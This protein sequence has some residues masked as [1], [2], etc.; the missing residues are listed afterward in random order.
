MRIKHLALAFCVLSLA[1]LCTCKKTSTTDNT[2]TS[3]PSNDVKGIIYTTVNGKTWNGD[4]PAKKYT[5]KYQDS[6]VSFGQDIYGIEGIIFG[7]TLTINTAR[8][9]GKDSSQIML[10]IVLK[11]SPTGNYT[12]GSY[13]VKTAGKAFAYYYPALGVKGSKL[14]KTAYNTTGTINISNLTDSTGLVSGTFDFTMVPKNASNPKTP[15]FTITGGR[16]KDVHYIP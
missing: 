2:N 16:F 1:F 8:V 6:F 11:S 7:D 12:V 4:G 3:N 9:S 5:V 15:K 14:G 13:P 10:E